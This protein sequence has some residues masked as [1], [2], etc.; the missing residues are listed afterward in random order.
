MK[1]LSLFAIAVLLFAGCAGGSGESNG[2][3]NVSV[4]EYYDD[5]HQRDSALLSEGLIYYGQ[6]PEA[7]GYDDMYYVFVADDNEMKEEAEKAL[8]KFRRKV[9]GM[10]QDERAYMA[11]VFNDYA[12]LATL[13]YYAYKDSDV[14]IPEGWTDLGAQDQELT[15]L[16]E[17]YTEQGLL[18]SGLKCSLMAKGDR[19]ALVFAGTDFPSEWSDM[20]QL[21]GFIADAYEDVD[22]ALNEDASQV[23]LAGHLVDDLLAKGYVTKDN[24]EFAGHSLGGRLA[25]EM[26]VR[27]GCP[28]VLFNAAGTSPEVYE[29]YESARMAADDQWNGYI[30]DVIAANDPLTCAQKYM[31]GSSDPFVSAAAEMLSVETETMDNLLSLGLGLLETVADNVSGGREIM[32]AAK[33]YSGLVDEFYERDYRALGAMMP[34]G[35]DMGGH[36]IKELAAA[37]RERAELCSSSSSK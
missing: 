6:N 14:A 25:S 32:N 33:E 27:Y 7:G 17:K 21:M 36:G 24:L 34:I 35:E 19:K 22:G 8:A 20:S 2:S 37:L 5:L 28:A 31:S 30:V 9:E 10:S 4:P 1:H 12:D 3:R 29:K 15:A 13:A 11:Y 16:I 26:A 23:V 18:S